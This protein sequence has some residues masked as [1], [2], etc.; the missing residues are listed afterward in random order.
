MEHV[1]CK[2]K[3]YTGLWVVG[4]LAALMIVFTPNTED[5]VLLSNA[6]VNSGSS[7][8]A[9]GILFFIM[10]LAFAFFGKNK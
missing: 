5:T 3:K 10:C 2:L 7:N 4:L 1:F 6:L 8:S 9:G